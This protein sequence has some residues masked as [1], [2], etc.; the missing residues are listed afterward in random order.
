[1]ARLERQLSGGFYEILSHIHHEIISGSVSCEL[2][3][4][5]D[6]VGKSSRC[7]VRVYERYSAF[8]GNRVS[9]SITLYQEGNGPVH[10]SAISS[11]GSQAIF[12]KLNTFSEEAFLDKL[13][14]IID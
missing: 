8:G 3:G 4:Q 14:E 5:S 6:F 12:A 10:L 2:N 11:G 1:M 13:R 9:L 7:S